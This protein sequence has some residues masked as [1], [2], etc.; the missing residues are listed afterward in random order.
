[1]AAARILAS[2]DLS[3]SS[4]VLANPNMINVTPVRGFSKVKD[5]ITAEVAV[6]E[7]FD[8]E[9]RE[10]DLRNILYPNTTDPNIKAISEANTI[11]EVFDIL[12]KAAVL[13]P[14]HLAQSLATFHTLQKIEA[15]IEHDFSA[16]F[17]EL[18]SK[19]N[20]NL[21]N[22]AKFSSL[23]ENINLAI[24]KMTLEEA[25]F[26]ILALRK[27]GVP[28]SDDVQV[29]LYLKLKHNVDQMDIGSIS[30]LS[31]AL[32]PRNSVDSNAP[33][34]AW[35]F[36]LL[37]F[38]PRLDELLE[39]CSTT[40]DL[41]KIAIC[42][43]NINIF[44]SD[45]M[46]KKFSDKF[47]SFV[48]AGMYSSADDIY[49]LKRVLLLGLY[50]YDWFA[51][52]TDFFS[53]L[54]NI[55]LGKL[56]MLRQSGLLYL[57]QLMRKSPCTNLQLYEECYERLCDTMAKDYPDKG[58]SYI[59]QLMVLTSLKHMALPQKTVK[60]QLRK[61]IGMNVMTTNI[62]DILS[63]IDDVYIY[64]HS[65]Q[66]ELFNKCF[67]SVKDNT[68]EI[69]QLASRLRRS[70]YTFKN[71]YR[72][73]I[74]E[75]KIIKYLDKAVLT[76]HVP[77]DIFNCMSILLAFDAEIREEHLDKLFCILGKLNSYAFS[78]LH[79]GL[80]HRLKNRSYTPL[81]KRSHQNDDYDMLNE[82]FVGVSRASQAYLMDPRQKLKIHDV[83]RFIR[84][85]ER[86]VFYEE[87]HYD[88]IN[89]KILNLKDELDMNSAHN[90]AGSLRL[91]SPF[92]EFPKVVDILEQFYIDNA[93]KHKDTSV[94][95][96]KL[97]TAVSYYRNKPL[98]PK[99][100][101]IISQNLYREMDLLSGKV[102]LEICFHL[103]G[104]QALPQFLS[105][106]IFSS[107][108]MEKLDNDIQ[109]NT[110]TLYTW[111]VRETLM[112]LNRCVVLQYPEHKV[113]WFHQ[114][115]C[116]Q[117]V[118]N[119]CFTQDSTFKTEVYTELCNAVGNW[120][121]VRMNS[122]SKYFNPVHMEL[123][124][125]ADG[126]L[127]DLHNER[128]QA[129]IVKRIAFQ[130]YSDSNYYRDTKRLRGKQELNN[131]QLSLQGW[132]VLNINPFSW[133]SMF[134]ADSDARVQYL[135]ETVK[136]ICRN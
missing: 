104:N 58:L 59:E 133:N 63:I 70:H 67:E 49:V 10:L 36:G 136:A 85:F 75:E 101:E 127:V 77:N 7:I 118:K 109:N 62:Y 20:Q 105:K 88:L 40:S 68:Q 99:L 34:N 117:H 126:H 28:L 79:D 4:S 23:L 61:F 92:V 98:N 43:T 29:K 52:N 95:S 46:M 64:D 18:V 31:N 69:C 15:N 37:P 25:A 116:Q 114:S 91:V 42:F 13:K 56:H 84:F 11:E 55:H 76:S 134:L 27:I 90:L 135:Q 128:E 33:I 81:L 113:P 83:T 120:R 48:E 102:I 9:I 2:R 72:N 93:H 53:A 26:S 115:F 112:E 8:S 21:L 82:I 96:L 97:F 71:K 16:Q 22:H 1:M 6:E 121:Y 14:Q 89:E 78:K 51:I 60:E 119:I 30:Y 35:K 54:I 66:D 111:Q 73:Q 65:I 132:Q 125:D 94:R 24:D 12:D 122:Y 130:A 17:I 45:K 32:R 108:F 44:V 19:F 3:L 41:S 5:N 100:V 131:L 87:S 86:N 123:G 107:D 74:L 38:V 129:N 57:F 47:K 80:R 106:E 124:L 110:N 50:K 39:T 103:A